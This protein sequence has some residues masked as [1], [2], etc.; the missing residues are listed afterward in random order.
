MDQENHSRKASI[1]QRE[2]S[3]LSSRRNDPR[4]YVHDINTPFEL[5]T[6]GVPATLKALGLLFSRNLGQV[7]VKDLSMG[8]VGFLASSQLQV[9]KRVLLCLDSCAPLACEILHQHS[10]APQ[11]CFYGGRW[12]ERDRRK[13]E[14]TLA[15][16]LTT[17]RKQKA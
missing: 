6:S 8:G 1:E 16:W 14:G 4:F 3:S 17:I 2:T 15:R 7:I 5:Q 12:Q 11:L 13:L 9:P 10:V